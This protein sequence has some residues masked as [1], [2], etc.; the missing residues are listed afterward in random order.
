MW[1]A[2]FL[3]VGVYVAILGAQCLGVEKFVLDVRQP[4]NQG[5]PSPSGGE[6]KLGPKTE[7]TPP[8]WAPWS[9]MSTGAVICLYSFSIPHRV[10]SR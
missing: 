5:F 3:A 7:L 4:A 2:F 10:K 9:L 1:R 8:D 6:A